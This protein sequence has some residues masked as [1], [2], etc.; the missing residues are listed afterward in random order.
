MILSSLFQ[1]YLATV[2]IACVDDI[3][4]VL[5][6]RKKLW[7]KTGIA[8]LNDITLQPSSSKHLIRDREWTH[9]NNYILDF[10]KDNILIDT[11]DIG[12]TFL[13]WGH[14][15]N[16]NN[17]TIFCICNFLTLSKILC[18]NLILP[19]FHNIRHNYFLKLFH[20]IKRAHMHVIN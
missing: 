3:K 2:H 16:F 12:Q 9:G 19:P 18:R 15:Y 5:N 4:D 6:I 17:W 13:N 11:Q 10:L 7:E 8:L 20:N 14:I 1:K